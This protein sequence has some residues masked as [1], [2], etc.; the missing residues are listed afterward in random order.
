[1]LKTLA[2]ALVLIMVVGPVAAADSFPVIGATYQLDRA[3]YPEQ[4][5]VCVTQSAMSKYIAAKQKNDTATTRRL[6]F[7]IDTMKDIEKMKKADGCTLISSTSQATILEK[8]VES[9]K[10][11]F[12]AFPL[13]PMWGWYL[14]FGG[15]VK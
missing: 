15:R 3:K 6:L 12:A 10:A 2:R 4:I 5:A 7:D 14:Y 13:E 11:R 1:M 8:G 9:H